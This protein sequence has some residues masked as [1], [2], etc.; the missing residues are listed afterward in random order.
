MMPL[1]A[2]HHSERPATGPPDEAF[3][4]MVRRFYAEAFGHGPIVDTTP[5]G[6]S[7]DALPFMA[8]VFPSAR[9]V[10]VHERA[11]ENIARRFRANP[12]ASFGALCNEW[13]VI[14]SGWRHQR[15]ILEPGRWLEID[16]REVALAPAAVATALSR[17]IDG[18]GVLAARIEA[19]LARFKTSTVVDSV[20][21]LDIAETPWSP[22]DI[23]TLKTHCSAEL[24]AWGYTLDTSYRAKPA[25]SP[26]GRETASVTP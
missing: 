10:F 18:T 3:L 17:L 20:S 9:I 8:R 2:E 12:E 26:S 22:V 6:P 14:L 11:L 25:E 16:Y 13:Q 5:S 15:E 21:P 19:E 1:F 24:A 23:A 4:D 7:I